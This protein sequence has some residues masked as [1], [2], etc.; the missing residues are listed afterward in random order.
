MKK[1]LLTILSILTAVAVGSA[2]YKFRVGFGTGKTLEV[3]TTPQVWTVTQS[4]NTNVATWY[5]YE[6]SVKNSGSTDLYFLKNCTTGELATAIAATNHMVLE[7]GD[8]Y[9]FTPYDATDMIESVALQSASAT[10][11]IVL[12]GH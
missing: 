1:T 8:V 2:A 10:N 4:G 9:V 6:V 11:T 5:C 3:T 12:N 7:S